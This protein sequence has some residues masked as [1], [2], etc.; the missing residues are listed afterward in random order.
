MRV[1]GLVTVGL[2]EVGVLDVF[3]ALHAN[4]VASKNDLGD[5]R[6]APAPSASQRVGEYSARSCLRSA[7]PLPPPSPPTCSPDTSAT[8][9]SSAGGACFLSCGGTP[10]SSICST[11]RCPTRQGSRPWPLRSQKRAP[12]WA[13]ASRRRRKA[14]RNARVA[15]LGAH[16]LPKIAP[17]A[18]PRPSHRASSS[19]SWKLK[20]LK[21]ARAELQFLVKRPYDDTPLP[22]LEAEQLGLKGTPGQRAADSFF[23]S[24]VRLDSR[25]K[26]AWYWLKALVFDGKRFLVHR[27][28]RRAAQAPRGGASTRL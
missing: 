18:E 12:R 7:A 8:H 5:A 11:R 26:H 3:V 20:L 17:R 24:P 9:T 22:G 13:A 28:H 15:V 16:R 25:L 23:K 2:V 19:S 1:L 14:H 27:A 6:S 4:R 21:H 10:G